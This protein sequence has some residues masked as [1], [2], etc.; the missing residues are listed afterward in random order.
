M[1][2][3]ASKPGSEDGV[4]Q[5]EVAVSYFPRIQIL[6]SEDSHVSELANLSILDLTRGQTRFRNQRT[7]QRTFIPSKIPLMGTMRMTE[8]GKADIIGDPRNDWQRCHVAQR[9]SLANLGCYQTHSP[10]KELFDTLS[11]ADA[12]NTIRLARNH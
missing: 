9:L 7:D 2:F 1:S 12:P 4:V 8:A 5:D 6:S 3:G 10:G 11:K